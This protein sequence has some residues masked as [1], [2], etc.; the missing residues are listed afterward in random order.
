[1]KKSYGSFGAGRTH[2]A[3]ASTRC[4]SRHKPALGWIRI[5]QQQ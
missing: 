2:N 3:P 1:L 5:K 4:D